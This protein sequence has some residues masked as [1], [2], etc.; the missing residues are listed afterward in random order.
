MNQA[1]VSIE[2]PHGAVAGQSGHGSWRRSDMLAGP[3][4]HEATGI[5]RG[6]EVEVPRG[7]VLYR[8]GDEAA[9]PYLVV[10]GV[11]RVSVA[12]ASGRDR[13]ADLV[14][15]GDVIGTAAIDGARHAETV[16]AADDAVVATI[17]L[18]GTL[19]RR[20]GRDALAAALVR[21]LTRSRALAD[22]LG[23]PMGARICRILA[24]LADRL[25]APAA[26]AHE[27][28]TAVAHHAGEPAWRHLPFPLTHDDVALLAGCARVT[29][30]RILGELKDAGVLDG[31][32]GNYALVPDALIEA[33]DRYVYDVL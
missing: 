13:L 7:R 9:T 11:L 3:P 23:L 4:K 21:Q 14:G 29:A 16:V 15:S 25:G 24:R 27:A 20:A 33:A 31:R 10:S 22:D 19:A 2:R 18:P 32:R 1:H 12:T 17:D 8:E 5:R 26:A 28:G 6:A 30:T